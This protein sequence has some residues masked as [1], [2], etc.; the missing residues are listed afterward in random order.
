MIANM[1]GLVEQNRLRTEPVLLA[2]L[3]SSVTWG[4]PTFSQ[5]RTG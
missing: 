1:L 4:S 2:R 3:R 5:S